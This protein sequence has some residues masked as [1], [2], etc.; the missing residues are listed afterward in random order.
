MPDIADDAPT[1]ALARILLVDDVPDNLAVLTGILEPEGHEILAA[2]G[3][4]TALKVAALAHPDLI[5]LDMMMPGMDGIETCRRLKLEAGTRETPII[6]ITARQ[7]VSSMVE[8]FR[9]GAVDYV[10]KPF[11]AG[12][13]VSRVTTHLRLSRL[14]RE[15]S[16]KNRA[17][18]ARTAELLAEAQ[19]RERAEQAAEHADEKLAALSGLEAERWNITGLIGASSHI[20][21]VIAGIQRVHPYA[22]TSV[23]IT[24]ESGTGK[25]LVARA[26]HFGSPRQ[27]GPFVPVNCVA[28]PT[29][30]AESLL[31]GHVKGAFTGAM[32]DRKGC[33]ELAH[34][35]T[36]F[37]DE[38]GD[39]PIA[40]QAKLLRVLED[41]RIT[42]VGSSQPRKVDV[43]IIAA[44]NAN[45]EAQIAAGSF[46]QDLYYR[47]ARYVVS[48]PPLRDHLQDVPLLAAHFLKTFAAEMGMKTPVLSDAALE[49][50][51]NHHFP[52][53]V[54][55]LRNIIERA[56]IESG[57]GIIEPEHLSL[58]SRV[59]ATPATPAAT[60]SSAEP[61]LESPSPASLDA[62]VE[63]LPL[64]LD[65]AED[66][67]IQRA[68]RETGGNIA[69]AAR[70]L[71]VHRTR[72]YRKLT[73]MPSAGEL[74]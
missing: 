22:N 17:L 44:T 48:T 64:N 11:Q 9:A 49:A 2:P 71:G 27:R 41:G 4:A 1:P 74:D 23:L 66:L 52:G 12:E 13:V 32:T 37:L 20:R 62:F 28:I 7:E 36:L 24:G 6:F 59:K 73:R 63:G 18:E 60:A 40:L 8:A 69:D 65:R 33:F 39:M 30:L 15:L 47:L 68:L 54:R 57:G 46:R 56:L 51:Q 34:R 43:R 25:E 29:E 55:E 14:A 5:L 31:F 19:R 58:P 70:L 21:S 10:V 50:L 61:S 35:G 53:N 26:I 45:L 72:I 67:L 42:P 38:I 16:E 3:G